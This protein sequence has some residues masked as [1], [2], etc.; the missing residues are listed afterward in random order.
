M[1]AFEA[2]AGA[3][4]YVLDEELEFLAPELV[5]RAHFGVGTSVAAEGSSKEAEV[6]FASDM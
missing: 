3:A 4:I 5:R 2:H 1:L 6:S